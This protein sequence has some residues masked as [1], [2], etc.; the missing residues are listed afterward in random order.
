MVMIPTTKF[1]LKPEYRGPHLTRY[2]LPS[3]RQCGVRRN[4]M[5]ISDIRKP[6]AKQL[7]R[8]CILLRLE[9]SNGRVPR[10]ATLKTL[11]ASR[12]IKEIEFS[13]NAT[14]QHKM[15]LVVN[16]FSQLNESNISR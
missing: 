12:R 7:S 3:H 16:G 15:E 2:H 8:T 11:E 4:S 14:A 1:A 6:R 13:N 9:D 10:P 5:R